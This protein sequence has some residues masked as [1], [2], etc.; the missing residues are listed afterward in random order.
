MT[1]ALGGGMVLGSKLL[2][3]RRILGIPIPTRRSRLTQAAK[4]LSKARNG[5]LE[6]GNRVD[7]IS[8]QVSAVNDGIQR[9]ASGATKD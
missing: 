5:I 9:I 7:A 6:T 3:K 8:K 1:V 4:S 2:P